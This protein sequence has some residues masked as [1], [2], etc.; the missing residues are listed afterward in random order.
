[1]A[2]LHCELLVIIKI[3][4]IFVF[5]AINGYFRCEFVLFSYY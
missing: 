4:N 1:M 5:N 2:L 3:V